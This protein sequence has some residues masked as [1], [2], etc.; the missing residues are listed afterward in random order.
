MCAYLVFWRRSVFWRAFDLFGEKVRD[1]FILK[2]LRADFIDAP[3]KSLIPIT[4]KG[5]SVYIQTLVLNRRMTPCCQPEG[6][7][8][9]HGWKTDAFSGLLTLLWI[10]VSN[11]F[12]LICLLRM[13]KW[14]P[15]TSTNSLLNVFLVEASFFVQ[16]PAVETWKRKEQHRNHF[17]RNSAISAISISC[18]FVR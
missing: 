8:R 11:A 18:V 14:Q 13:K 5:V 4:R 7:I 2:G 1:V 17:S 12:C 3:C 10:P 15:A 16:H 9:C 6:T